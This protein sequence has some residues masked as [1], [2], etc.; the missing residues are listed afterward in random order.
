MTSMAGNPVTNRRRQV[1]CA[2]VCAAIAMLAAY[3][4][5]GAEEDWPTRMHDVYRSG[6]TPE[7][8]ALPLSPAW[9]HT[10]SSAPSPAWTESPARHDYLHNAY[11]LKPRQHFDRCFEAV[12][13]GDRLYFGSSVSGAVTCLDTATG[14][15]VWTFFTG[16]PV[17]FAPHVADG[18]VYAGSDD[19]HLYCLRAEDGSLIW[20]ERAGPKDDMVWGNQHMISIWPV[21]SSATV[22][23]GHVFWTAGVFPEEGIYLCKRKAGD[24]SGGWTQA[25][26]APPQGYLAVLG[27][28]LVVP[29]G[30]AFPRLYRRDTGA[31]AGDIKHD[32]RDGGSWTVISPDQQELW[33]GPSTKNESQAFNT[34][35]LARIAK[36]PGA[37]CLIVDASHAYYCT[38]SDLVKL[39]RA[40]RKETWRKSHP[41]PHALIKA[42]GTL[43][44]GGKEEVAA[45]DLEGTLTWK[46]PVDG[47]AYALAAARGR[48]YVSTDAGSIHCFQ[49]AL[50]N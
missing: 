13:V 27:D 43:F 21:R 22:V 34:K 50:F 24:G 42:G 16:A 48:L 23:D 33:F 11:D 40:S 30:K 7:Q 26:V 15:E 37:N 35:T 2:C 9:T 17:R 32:A 31:A 36:V 49:S 4:P 5:A 46:A 19:G 41:Y 38:D 1:C 10:A 3:C 45:F 39:E 14:D 12:A 18:K 25:A 28:R 29:S 20:S 6:I 47:N 8:L 44:A